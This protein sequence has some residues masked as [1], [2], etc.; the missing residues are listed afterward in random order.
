MADETTEQ[1]G[2]GSTEEAPKAP[3][4]AGEGEASTANA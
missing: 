2:S 3:E 4:G 1:A